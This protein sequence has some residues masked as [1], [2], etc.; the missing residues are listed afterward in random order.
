MVQPDFDWL[1]PSGYLPATKVNLG[2]AF[3]DFMQHSRPPDFTL[4]FKP[5]PKASEPEA[6]GND[7]TPWTTTMRLAG[8]LARR[9]L[10][11]RNDLVL[12]HSPAMTRLRRARFNCS[13]IPPATAI[14]EFC[15]NR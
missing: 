2:A 7:A 1:A 11:N 12:P 14:R 3:I 4:N 13:W 10:L 5:E 6:A 15:T 9:P 8:E